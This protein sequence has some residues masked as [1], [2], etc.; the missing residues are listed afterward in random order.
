M[1]KRG[2]EKRYDITLRVGLTH[3][4]HNFIEETSELQGVKKAEVVRRM[5]DTF[6]PYSL[7]TTQEEKENA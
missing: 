7:A 3:S 4:Q 1:G 5:I 6:F 2:P